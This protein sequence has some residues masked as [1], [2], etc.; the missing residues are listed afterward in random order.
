L[1]DAE[2][3][4]VTGIA[5]LSV[6]DKSLEAITGGSNVGPILESFW[7]WRNN[8]Y[9]GDRADSL[10]DSP[11]NLLRPKAAGMQSLGR[12]GDDRLGGMGMGLGG[13]RS[14]AMSK[15]MES[16]A[17]G[18]PPMAMA[19]IHPTEG[20]RA[21]PAEPCFWLWRVRRALSRR[22]LLRAWASL[23]CAKC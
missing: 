5:V 16:D 17:F 7:T 10:P 1:K 3:K 14:G 2:G 4:P 9:P 12:F 13:N 8:F 6:Y 22:C 19:A 21:R 23:S 20:R 18:G 11:G 15:V